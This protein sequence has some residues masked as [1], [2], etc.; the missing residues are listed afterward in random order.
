MEETLSKILEKISF[1]EDD[2][3]NIKTT[4]NDKLTNLDAKLRGLVEVNSRLAQE[5]IAIKENRKCD[6]GFDSNTEIKT[7]KESKKIFKIEENKDDII[8]SGSTYSHRSFIKEL[9][10]SW[11]SSDKSWVLKSENKDEL[12]KYLVRNNVEYKLVK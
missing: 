4:V 9:G 8:V 3:I 1:I 5:I 11:N 7:I 2:V 10:G 12:M 6:N